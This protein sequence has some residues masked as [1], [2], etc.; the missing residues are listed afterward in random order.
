MSFTLATGTAVAIA[1]AF[2][3]GFTISA[4]S[5]ANPAIASLS[6]S[7][8]VVVGDIIEVSSGWDLLDKRLI[9]VSVVAG[10]DVTLEGVNTL[11][12]GRFPAGTGAGTGREVTGWTNIAQIKGMDSSGGDLSYANIT[13]WADRVAK[14]IPTIRSAKELNF[15]VY[16]DPALAWYAIAEAATDLIAVTGLRFVFSNGAKLY[17]N[18]YYN[19]DPVP[20]VTSQEVLTTK[21]GFSAVS[22]PIRYAS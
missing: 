22:A 11:N 6:S 1:S 19:L 16:D 15:V 5:N 4:I 10:D 13:T 21:L 8:G 17:A 20:D 12:T 2:G 3:T 14:Q 18:G 9:R 7:H